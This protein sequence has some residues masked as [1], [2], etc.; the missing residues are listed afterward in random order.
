MLNYYNFVLLGLLRVDC[1]SV[2]TSTVMRRRDRRVKRKNSRST[3]PPKNEVKKFCDVPVSEQS[4]NSLPSTYPG[5]VQT[6]SKASVSTGQRPLHSTNQLNAE[7]STKPMKP[8]FIHTNI[9]AT[10]SVLSKLSLSSQPI[11]KIRKESTQVLLATLEDKQK[12]LDKLKEDKIKFHTFTDLPN[13][14]SYF[15]LKGFYST[16]CEE[17]LTL[18]NSS[19]IPALKVSFFINKDDFSIYLVHFNNTMNI[20]MLNNIHKVVDGI[21]IKWEVL[22]KASKR[23]TQCFRCQNWGHASI[24]C[25]LDIRC[26]K[27]SNAH[28]PGNCPRT[29]REGTPT[30]CNCGGPHAANFRG[31]VNYIKHIEKMKTRQKKPQNAAPASRPI[32]P[33]QWNSPTQFP[34]LSSQPKPQD[35]PSSSQ[36]NVSYA[37]KVKESLNYNDKVDKLV[38]VMHK[39]STA[40]NMDE[41]IDLITSMLE[42]LISC[43]D[44]KGRCAIV[45]KYCSSFTTN[46]HGC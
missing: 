14:P 8:V 1:T 40:P 37:K 41:S 13:K 5:K 27:C 34:V 44:H 35:G 28:E 11:C 6:T 7:S 16:T 30:C 20:M 29:S 10:K 17:M 12:L 42:E 23:I 2:N 22:R 38:N 24:N 45:L 46:N 32:H 15:L 18:L 26:V 9:N 36:Y 31:C 19:G 4:T 39:F 3:S 43:N 33:V 25:G 21:A